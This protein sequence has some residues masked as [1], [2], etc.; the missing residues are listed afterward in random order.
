MN[1]DKIGQLKLAQKIEFARIVAAYE[2]DHCGSASEV[3]AYMS[4]DAL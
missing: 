1:S 2:S 3:G 4:S